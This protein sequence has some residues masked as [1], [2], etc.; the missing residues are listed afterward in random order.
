MAERCHFPCYGEVALGPLSQPEP[1][2]SLSLPRSPLWGRPLTLTPPL[3]RSPV[4]LGTCAWQ[5][6]SAP[7]S[8][9][10]CP[11]S[12]PP[13]RKLEGSRVAKARIKFSLVSLRSE[14]LF[15]F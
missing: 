7:V 2:P 1:L 8:L 3:P 9:Q 5:V 4:A 15:G 12:P 11:E 6:P 14:C 10:H 13:P